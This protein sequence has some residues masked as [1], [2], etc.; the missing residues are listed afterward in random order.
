MELLTAVQS[1]RTM[2]AMKA[3]E[4]A[5]TKAGELVFAKAAASDDKKDNG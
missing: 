3:V 1:E 2:V 4:M 5:R